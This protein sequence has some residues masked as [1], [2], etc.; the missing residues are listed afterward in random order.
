MLAC[1]A[2]V[3]TDVGGVVVGVVVEGV[4]VGVGVGI[5]VVVGV[6]TGLQDAITMDSAINIVIAIH[7]I[8]F[9]I[10]RSS[11]TIITLELTPIPIPIKSTTLLNYSGKDYLYR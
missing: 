2:C 1:G 8:F 9:F 4:V 3:G 6:A 7:R 11:I 10:S 5:G